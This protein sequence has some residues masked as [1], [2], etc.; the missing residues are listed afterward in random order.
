MALVVIL[1]LALVAVS[2]NSRN[3]TSSP[4]VGSDHWHAAYGVY[5]CVTDSFL[6]DFQ[7]TLDPDGIHSHQDGLVHI[8]PFNGSASGS[9]ANFDVFLSS[10]NASITTTEIA[11]PDFATLSAGVECNGEP[12]VIRVARYQVD[13]DV[14]LLEVFDSGFNDIHFD[15]NRQAFTIARVAPS[16]DPPEPTAESLAALDESTGSPQLSEAPVT[17]DDGGH[18]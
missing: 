1:G 16:Q 14:Q 9:D 4:R 18:G 5:D 11:S 12:S 10:M 7:G 15:E 8:H 2:R 13:P 6:P 3:A 17:G